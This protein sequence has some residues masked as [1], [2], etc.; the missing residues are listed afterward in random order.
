[1]GEYYAKYEAK[2]PPEEVIKNGEYVKN[3]DADTLK[4]YDEMW[5]KLKQ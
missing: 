5:T 4:I 2:N 1:M 3:L